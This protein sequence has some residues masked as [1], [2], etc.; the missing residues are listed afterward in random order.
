[1]D[2]D[3]GKRGNQAFDFIGM[4]GFH[5]HAG[6]LR[7]VQKGRDSFV[8]GDINGDGKAD[9]AL[10]INGKVDFHATDFHL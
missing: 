9:F 4:H 5:H 7:Y 6:E 2:A 8:Y 1:M 10:E 3:T